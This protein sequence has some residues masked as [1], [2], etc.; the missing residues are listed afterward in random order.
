M[1]FL[2]GTEGKLY[3][4]GIYI[5]IG[6]IEEFSMTKSKIEIKAAKNLEKGD[7]IKSSTGKVFTVSSKTVNI[8]R[9]IVIFDGD[10]E[11]DFEN[12]QQ[13]EVY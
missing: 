6:K 13:L 3:I 10:I 9:T 1:S 8:K 12:Y 5:G 11:I 4:N 7:K 2:I